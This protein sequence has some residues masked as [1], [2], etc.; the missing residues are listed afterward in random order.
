MR[1][2]EGKRVSGWRS[3]AWRW[4]R[5]ILTNLACVFANCLEVIM[6]SPINLGWVFDDCLEVDGGRGSPPRYLVMAQMTLIRFIHT[7]RFY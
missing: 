3:Q 4:R 7:V 1:T 2:S 5:T 6:T